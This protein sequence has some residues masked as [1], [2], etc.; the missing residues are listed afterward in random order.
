MLKASLALVSL[1]IF[2]FGM[3]MN[4]IIC[5]EYQVR[6]NLKKWEGDD[7]NRVGCLDWC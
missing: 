3:D 7:K 2:I 1:C 4:G 6:E 5:K